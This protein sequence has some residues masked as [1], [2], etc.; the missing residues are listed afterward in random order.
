MRCCATPHCP[1]LVD[2]GH[3]VVHARTKDE[4]RGTAQER[5]YDS[6][7]NAYSHR[8]RAAHPLCGERADGSMDRHHSRCVQE[9]KETPAQ[10]VDHTIPMSQGGSKWDRN[11]HMS[12]C[13]ACNSWKANTIEKEHANS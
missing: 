6:A 2:K 5:G 4:H 10:C 7:W 11:N 9:G 3:C 12:A 8:F 1:E 13:F